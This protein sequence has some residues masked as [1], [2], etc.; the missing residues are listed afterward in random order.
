MVRPLF[1]TTC[2]FPVLGILLERL[3][4]TE[5]QHYTT[6]LHTWTPK[7]KYGHQ[8]ILSKIQKISA[9]VYKCAFVPRVLD[10]NRGRCENSWMSTEDSVDWS[11]AETECR[12]CYAIL[13]WHVEIDAPHARW[14]IDFGDAWRPVELWRAVKVNEI[15]VFGERGVGR[16]NWV[17]YED[18]IWWRADWQEDHVKAGLEKLR[19]DVVSRRAD[20]RFE[21]PNDVQR[22]CTAVKSGYSS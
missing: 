21:P 14:T 18:D 7:L 15:F 5:L 10:P 17:H 4:E 12:S 2:I 6:T 3:E 9:K 19:A 16:K 13:G 1:F 8:T 22:L 20:G 11:R